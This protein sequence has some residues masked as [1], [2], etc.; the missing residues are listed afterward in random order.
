[1]ESC[2]VGADGVVV[3]DI[4]GERDRNE[5]FTGLPDLLVGL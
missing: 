4:A 2:L 1:M 3:W 5:V